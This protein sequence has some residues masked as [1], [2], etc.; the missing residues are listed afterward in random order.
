MAQY[1]PQLSATIQFKSIRNSNKGEPYRILALHPDCTNTSREICNIVTIGH[2]TSPI[3]PTK[4]CNK[5][6]LSLFEI[7]HWVS[8]IKEID[9]NRHLAVCN[10]QI[11]AIHSGYKGEQS[12]CDKIHIL[13]HTANDWEKRKWMRDKRGLLVIYWTENIITS[14]AIG[15]IKTRKYHPIYPLGKNGH[16]KVRIER[17]TCNIHNTTEWKKIWVWQQINL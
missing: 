6:S 10:G 1:L 9:T 12:D 13:S 14:H 3:C 5:T 16:H 7:S 2:N 15:P 4:K 17:N 8:Q 11:F